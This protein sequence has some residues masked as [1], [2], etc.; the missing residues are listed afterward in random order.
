M[1]GLEE[2]SGS[3]APTIQPATE[4]VGTGLAGQ[5]RA[6]VARADGERRPSVAHLR[7]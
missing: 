1:N 5:G 4:G 7:S 3:V 2:A 6:S